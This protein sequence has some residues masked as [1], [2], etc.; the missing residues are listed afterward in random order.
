MDLT[1]L[2]QPAPSQV[3]TCWGTPAWQ[4]KGGG[5]QLPSRKPL[6]QGCSLQE[7]HVQGRLGQPST[8]HLAPP[9]SELT[10]YQLNL[11]RW[12]AVLIPFL[13]GLSDDVR[14]PWNPVRFSLWEA[15][16]FCLVSFR[17]CRLLLSVILKLPSD[18]RASLGTCA[19]DTCLSQEFCHESQKCNYQVSPPDQA[20]WLALRTQSR[21]NSYL[22]GI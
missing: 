16:G 17:E 22:V 19:L 9:Y 10:V 14:W 15:G 12:T 4:G 11:P 1:Q 2:L 3:L 21:H 20:L 6:L 5:G 8:N 13:K 7:R 18:P